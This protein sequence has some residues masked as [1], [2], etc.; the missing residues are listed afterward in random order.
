[1]K[2]HIERKVVIVVCLLSLISGL[3]GCGG[4]KSYAAEDIASVSTAY[5][6]TEKNPVYSFALQKKYDALQKKDIWFFS[7][8]CLVGEKKEHYTSFSFFPTPTDEAE[9]F[10]A[11]IREEGEIARL[12]KHCN[13]L[14]IF[15]IPDAP[16]RS[17]VISFADGGRI[18]KNIEL[19]DKVL[20]YLFALADRHFEAAESGNLKSV[21]IT[22]NAM[23]YSYCYMFSIDKEEGIW[24]LSCDAVVDDER[25]CAEEEALR[26][27]DG[28]AE[29]ILAVVR[30][31]QLVGQ[32][33]QYEEPEDDGTFVLDETT[34]G[35]AFVFT[36]DSRVYA[37]IDHGDELTEAF[38][39]LVRK[40]K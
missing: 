32:V 8:S 31:Q 7:A 21:C 14:R 40:Y 17:C 16:S 3:F 15:H 9:G 22:S 1:M 23:D 36:D 28:D 37:P 30:E 35:T 27:G 5:Y 38:R 10:L 4:E 19:G 13:P 11:L 26:I 25:I 39:R 20:D 24:F 12:R 29:E 34:Y 33:V 18:E 2:K 6:G